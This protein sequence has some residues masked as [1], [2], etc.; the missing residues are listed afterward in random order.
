MFYKVESEPAL[1]AAELGKTLKSYLDG[2]PDVCFVSEDGSRV[3]TKRIAVTMYSSYFSDILSSFTSSETPVVSLPTAS[4]DAVLYLISMLTEGSTASDSKEVLL[5]SAKI[6]KI[7]GIQVNGIQIGE[8]KKKP[9]KVKNKEQENSST[10][11]NVEIGEDNDQIKLMSSETNNK[12]IKAKKFKLKIKEHES[13]TT[14]VQ[15]CDDNLTENQIILMSSEIKTDEVDTSLN[16]EEEYPYENND[17]I[18]K[19]E[20]SLVPGEIP[21]HV[22]GECGKTFVSPRKL[23][24]HQVVHTSNNSHVCGECGKAFISS[25]KLKRH[26]VV[27]TGEKPFPCTFEGCDKSFSLVSNL[28][29]HARIHTGDR[30]YVCPFEGCDKSFTQS[31]NRKSHILTHTKKKSKRRNMSSNDNV[32]EERSS[33]DNNMQE[34]MSSTDNMQE[35]MSSTDNMQEEMSTTDNMQEEMSSTDYMQEEMSSICNN[36]ELEMSSHEDHQLFEFRE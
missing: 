16:N 35:E 23:K 4:S 21:D 18:S 36:V 5:E 15:T 19:F 22:C 12:K 33:T 7:I 34:E 14:T 6:A 29:T 20:V 27:H 10:T 13:S 30:P 9:K 28:R 3:F 11:T 31:T 24:R 32:Q 17:E 25:S 8:K 1:H 2:D 26:Q